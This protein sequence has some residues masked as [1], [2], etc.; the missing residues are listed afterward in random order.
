MQHNL[1]VCSFMGRQKHKLM[2]AIHF[3]YSKS[4]VLIEVLWRSNTIF[5]IANIFH[6]KLIVLPLKKLN[7]SDKSLQLFSRWSH[8]WYLLGREGF[9][10]LR[11]E[12]RIGRYHLFPSWCLHYISSVSII[13]KLDSLGFQLLGRM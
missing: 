1:H 4:I 2:K 6:A 11:H 13:N 10:C 12:V 7:S 9:E 3:Y 5:S 8:G